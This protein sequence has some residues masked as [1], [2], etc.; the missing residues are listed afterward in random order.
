VALAIIADQLGIIIDQVRK[1]FAGQYALHIPKMS[2]GG[3][4]I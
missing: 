3:S 4:V 2:I 1:A